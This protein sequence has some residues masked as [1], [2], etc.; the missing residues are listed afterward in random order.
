[1]ST[2]LGSLFHV[3]HSLVKSLSPTWPFEEQ[4]GHEISPQ[5]TLFWA[6]Q[7][8]GSHLLLIHSWPD[9]SPSLLPSFGQSLYIFHINNNVSKESFLVINIFKHS[10][11]FSPCS[12]LKLFSLYKCLLYMAD[13]GMGQKSWVNWTHLISK[14][15]H[16]MEAILLARTHDKMPH[17]QQV[18][19]TQGWSFN[20]MPNMI[21]LCFTA[22]FLGT[23][24][25]IFSTSF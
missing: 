24:G 9:L 20:S 18:I 15:N 1:M 21:F 5:L 22:K 16:K 7:T 12:S 14:Q 19:H 4:Q 11:H 25:L 6:E 13:R 8:Q 2:A 3:H 23:C 17:V 10:S